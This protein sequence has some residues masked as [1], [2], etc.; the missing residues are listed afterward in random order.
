[1]DIKQIT[2]MINDLSMTMEMIVLMTMIENLR[3]QLATYGVRGP[4][5]LSKV[6]E[7]NSSHCGG[8]VEAKRRRRKK[9]H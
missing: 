4:F 8:M 3:F 6:L 9:S 5:P 1:M 7:G 2:L